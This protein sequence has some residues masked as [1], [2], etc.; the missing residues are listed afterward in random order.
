VAR[1]T[2]HINASAARVFDVLSDGWLY[3][4]WVV[5]TSHMRAVDERWPAVGSKLFHAAGA[6][7]VMTR[8]ETE[9][10]AIEPGRS[11]SLIARGRPVGEAA[12]RIEL[13]EKNGGCDVVMY[14]EPTA[15]PGKW[16]HNPV[17]EAVLVRR[18]TESLAR[19]AALC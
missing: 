11:L 5:G 17:T 14:E 8:D 9:V 13:S 18:N 19:F 15:G 16:L 10:T 7:P 12:I 3:T 2:V 6:W 1:N 4:N